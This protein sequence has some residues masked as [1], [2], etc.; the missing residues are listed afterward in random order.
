MRADWSPVLTVLN[1][2]HGIFYLF[3]DPNP[4]DPLNQE[5]AEMFR[6]DR[7]SFVDFVKRTLKGGYIK[8]IQFPKLVWK[9]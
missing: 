5:A 8:N 9:W 1:V 4:N 7:K 2:I 3:D 6:D